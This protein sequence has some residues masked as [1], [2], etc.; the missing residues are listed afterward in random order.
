MNVQRT[1]YRISGLSR[2]YMSILFNPEILSKVLPFEQSE[3][4]S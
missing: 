3:D 2:I 1:V 4:E